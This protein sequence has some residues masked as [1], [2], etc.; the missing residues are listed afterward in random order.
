MQNINY[1]G[2][3]NST[4]TT[5]MLWRM[6]ELQSL[7]LYGS[8]NNLRGYSWA[9]LRTNFHVGRL[10]FDAGL[11]SNIVSDYIFLTH[12]HSDHSASLY[13]HTLWENHQTIFVPSC[14]KDAAFDL[15]KAQ[16]TLSAI[17]LPFDV[18]KAS[19]TIQPVNSGERF[20]I[21]H[22]GKS[23][24]VEVFEND[25]SVPCVSYG[26]REEIK[27]IKPEY[28]Q[29]VK[30]GR[31]KEVGQLRRQGAEVEEFFFYPRFVYIGDTTE[32]VFDM[33]P[34][35]F[36]YKDI[37]I[38]C[39]FLEDDDLEQA[40]KTKHCHW[41]RLRP[42]IQAHPNNRFI[43]Y[44]FSTRYKKADIDHFFRKYGPNNEPN[45]IAWTNP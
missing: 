42:I 4:S 2:E 21:K 37:I 10:M 3:T 6:W 1:C 39:T 43:L 15:I 41:T 25:H 12:G 23:H 20:Q 22:N 38:E 32:A 35:L 19:F 34:S 45:V 33:H 7:P 8:N 17:N 26:I 27:R 14:L 9:A 31:G 44:H 36:D 5:K 30:E 11:S 28:Q 24:Q 40:T 13:F 29:L 18:E 16:F